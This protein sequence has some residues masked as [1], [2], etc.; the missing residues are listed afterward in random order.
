MHPAPEAREIISRG[1]RAVA[2]SKS[3]LSLLDTV[4]VFVELFRINQSRA[5]SVCFLSHLFLKFRCM[6]LFL[7]INHLMMITRTNGLMK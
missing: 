1:S 7:Y 3:C 5:V 2:A 4:I 6:F